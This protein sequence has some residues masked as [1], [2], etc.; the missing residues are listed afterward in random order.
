MRIEGAE[1]S[2][3]PEAIELFECFL[4]RKFPKDYRDFLLQYN[5]GSVVPNC[6]DFL[7]GQPGSLVHFFMKINSKDIYND[8]LSNIRTFNQRIPTSFISIAGDPFGNQVCIAISGPEYGKI[9]F[10]DHENEADDGEPATMDNMTLIT[11]NFSDF[12]NSLHLPP[13][14]S[15][16]TIPI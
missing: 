10:W 13:E 2:V 16:D 12:L 5:G 6:F 14:K 4:G 9:Y 1:N 7:N 3:G 11:Q 15:G 8:L